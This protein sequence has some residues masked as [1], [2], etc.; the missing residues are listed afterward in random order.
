MRNILIFLIGF[1]V[2]FFSFASGFGFFYLFQPCSRAF[3]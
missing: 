3:V 1:A 2:G